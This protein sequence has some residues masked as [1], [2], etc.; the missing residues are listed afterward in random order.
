MH[1][2]ISSAGGCTGRRGW[3]GALQGL[4][5]CL[6]QAVAHQEPP[7]KPR[8]VAACT[9]VLMEAHFLQAGGGYGGS[10]GE[11]WMRCQRQPALNS[12]GRACVCLQLA[13]CLPGHTTAS[14]RPPVEP[15]PHVLA[16]QKRRQ[17][18]RHRLHPAARHNF[19]VPLSRLLMVLVSDLAHLWAAA[20]SM[21]SA[22]IAFVRAT[23]HSACTLPPQS[24]RKETTRHLP[25][26]SLR[27]SRHSVCP[28]ARR[29]P[30][31][32][33]LAARRAQWWT[34][35]PAAVAG[36]RGGQGKRGRDGSA[37]RVVRQQRVVRGGHSDWWQ[38]SSVPVSSACGASTC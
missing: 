37:E 31:Q 32:A 7:P 18:S 28:G 5:S 38:L 2:S 25:R 19:D 6:R 27:L 20:S 9:T 36:R 17:V 13:A 29:P 34:Q 1:S 16:N 24:G 35:P 30:P 14:P 22:V 21:N 4:T 3:K 23:R 11:H 10:I 15:V 33:P 26:S 8:P 12:Q